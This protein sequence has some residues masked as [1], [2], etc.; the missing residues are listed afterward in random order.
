MI[1]IL[2]ADK[3]FSLCVRERADNT[4]ERCGKVYSEGRGLQCCHY[5]SRRNYS[6]RFEPLN[7]FALCYGCH[8]LLDGSPLQFTKFY[9]DKLGQWE[10]SLLSELSCDIKRGKENKHNLKEIADYYR[11]VYESMLLQRSYGLTGYLPFVGWN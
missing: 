10:L 7:A 5:E 11:E 9:V 6:T 3:Y 2:P 4:C 8:Q 1:K